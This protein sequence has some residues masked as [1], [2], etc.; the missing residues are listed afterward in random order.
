MDTIVYKIHSISKYREL[1]ACVTDLENKGKGVIKIPDNIIDGQIDYDSAWLNLKLGNVFF[2]NY[3]FKAE[4]PSS[5]TGIYITYSKAEDLIKIEFSIPKYFFGNNV[6]E[7]LPS[8][9]SKRYRAS[10]QSIINIALP[11]WFKILHWLP[12]QIV[13]QITGGQ[14]YKVKPWHI[15][16]SR[17]DICFNQIFNCCSDALFYLESQTRLKLRNQADS[18]SAKYET[19]IDFKNDRYYFKV[20]HKGTEFKANSYDQILK[21]TKKYYDNKLH[22]SYNSDK[23]KLNITPLELSATNID[24]LQEYA[25]KILR[26]ELGARTAVMSYLF[27]Y[28]LKKSQITM[29]NPTNGN[30]VKAFQVLIKASRYFSK[31]DVFEHAQ[32]LK[33]RYYTVYGTWFNSPRPEA[34]IIKYYLPYSM[35]FDT[36]ETI[37]TNPNREL[38]QIFEGSELYKKVRTI[39]YYQR[40]LSKY[41][42]AKDLPAVKKLIAFVNKDINKHHNFFLALPPEVECAAG[43]DNLYLQSYTQQLFSYDLFKLLIQKFEQKFSELQF[44]TLPIKSKIESAVA[45]LNSNRNA[46]MNVQHVKMINTLLTHYT[47]DELAKSGDYSRKTL[48]NWRKKLEDLQIADGKENYLENEFMNSVIKDLNHLYG[49]HYNWIVQNKIPLGEFL[50]SSKDLITL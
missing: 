50:N 40:F 38:T 28:N 44:S 14:L 41:F 15:E 26:Y 8:M 47:W 20:Y 5:A 16:I 3:S 7:I 6:C 46:Q 34:K 9:I 30:K 19:A 49:R 18:K 32:H 11:L 1:L 27:N 48:Y 45:I 29:K 42:G 37:G 24:A 22:Q 13:M 10:Y 23:S 36:K 21:L 17:I 4:L 33:I 12:Q 31:P 35:V 39:H 43:T 25:D 2:F